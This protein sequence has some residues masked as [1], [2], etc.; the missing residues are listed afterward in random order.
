MKESGCHC[1]R[2]F[3]TVTTCLLVLMNRGFQKLSLQ[4]TVTVTAVTLTSDHCSPNSRSQLCNK[5]EFR[6]R[7]PGKIDRQREIRLRYDRKG[8]QSFSEDC[9]LTHFFSNMLLLSHCV[10]GEHNR[11]LF[12]HLAWNFCPS[13]VTQS[14]LNCNQPVQPPYRRGHLHSPV[15]RLSFKSSSRPHH[16]QSAPSLIEFGLPYTWITGDD[17]SPPA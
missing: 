8:I 2:F 5:S 11:A 12:A 9:L 4:P 10:A 14:Q 6:E 15:S 16:G 13:I 17:V 7:L 1:N 3:V